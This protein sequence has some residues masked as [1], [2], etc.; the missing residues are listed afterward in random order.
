MSVECPNHLGFHRPLTE[1]VRETLRVRNPNN[2]PV[3]FKVKT[4][5]PKLYCVRPNSG[6]IEAGQEIEV[7]VLLQAMKEEPPAD[8][9]CRDKFLVQSTAISPEAES[10][11][12][13]ELWSELERSG[14][15][16]V[17]ERKIRCLFLPA[18]GSA[19]TP[20]ASITNGHGA[21]SVGGNTPVLSSGA[22]SHE[23]E[24]RAPAEPSA[25]TAVYD[26]SFVSTAQSP[27]AAESS[28]QREKSASTSP[29]EDLNSLRA[30]NENL[31][32]QLRRAQQHS[33]GSKTVQAAQGVPV[34]I[35][36]LLALV[37]F[38]AAYLLF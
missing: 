12:I 8:F 37:A 14:K 10:A 16:E 29:T 31:R 11:S 19:A 5:A 13:S 35:S 7:Q 25:P 24:A 4:T 30:E 9:K 34:H 32:Q 20:S 28:G 15:H 27:V 21:A 6:R 18:D 1:L 33:G 17:H 2:T 23:G 36:A 3:A 26:S 22:L 38:L